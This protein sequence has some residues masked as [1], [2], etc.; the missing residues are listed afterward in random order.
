MNGHLFPAQ[1]GKDRTRLTDRLA[2]LS[3]LVGQAGDGALHHRLYFRANFYV[4]F[5]CLHGVEDIALRKTM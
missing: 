3:V 1:A 2:F 5:A 4:A